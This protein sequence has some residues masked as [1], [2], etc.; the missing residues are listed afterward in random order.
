MKRNKEYSS[1]KRH[2]FTEI[3]S[4]FA[5]Y[6]LFVVTKLFLLNRF[7]EIIKMLFLT[8]ETMI[9]LSPLLNVRS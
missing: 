9:S 7:V 4:I 1:E 6:F 2:L 8:Q 3:E 5:K